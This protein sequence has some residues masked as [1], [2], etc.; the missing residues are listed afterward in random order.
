[1]YVFCMCVHD[2]CVCVFSVVDGIICVHDTVQVFFHTEIFQLISKTA[3]SSTG[4]TY[5][6]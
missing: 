6:L 5:T 4:I 2:M 1:M 3:G